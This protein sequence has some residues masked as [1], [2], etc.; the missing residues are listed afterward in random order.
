MICISL[1]WA[2]TS[3]SSQ[4]YFQ[5]EVNYNIHV[6]LNDKLHELNAFETVE[7]VNK[8]PDTLRFLFFH[9]W[10]NAYS[11]NTTGLARQ[12]LSQKGKQRLFND[13]ELKGYI[14]SLDFEVE[15]AP[16]H[17][18]LLP[19]SSDICRIVLN[20]PV[21]PGDTII[22]TTPFHVKIPMGVTSRLGYIGESY[23]IS[24]WY[25]KPAVYDRTGWHPMQYLDQGEFYSE[26]G[27]FD[28]SITLPANYIVGA[29]GNLQN[30]QEAEWL[31]RLASDTSWKF[32]TDYSYSG[33]PP[34]SK[35]LKTLRY[36]ENMIH[37]FAWFADKRFHVMKGKVKLPESGREV[38][39]F[40]LFTNEQAELWKNALKYVNKAILYLSNLIGDYPYDTFTAVQ[41]ALTAGEGMEYPGITVIGLADDAYSLDKVI[42]HEV[43]HSWFYSAL[44]SDERRYPFMDEGI[45]SAYEQRY[46]YEKYP[47]KKLWELYFKKEK[48]AKFFH[49][50]KMP[51]KRGDELEWLFQ[52]RSNLE[53]PV[54][55]A[56]TDYN[57][58]NYSLML[59]YKAGMGF[60]YVRNW[61]GD[62]L[63]DSTMH[64]YYLK[65]KFKHPYPDDIRRIFE[66]HTD[67]D[68]TWFF[69]DFLGTTRR[70]DYKVS[71]LRNQQLLVKNVGEMASPLVICGMNGDSIDFVKWI[72]GFE[73]KKWV[74]IPPGN[75]S[76]IKIDPL[77]IT[78][79]LY[80]LNNNI[81]MYG[82]FP[83]ADPVLTQ[84]F[85]TI[86]D[87]DKRSIMFIPLVNWNKEDGFMA[88]LAL[89]NGLFLPKHFEYFVV[90]FYSV[91]NS[92]MTGYGRIS[93]NIMPWNNLIRMAKISLEGT[94]FGALGTQNYL[95]AKFGSELYLRNTRLNNPL[96][97]MIYGY[98]NYASDLLQIELL[99]KAKMRTYL[100]FGYLMQK[101]DL[102][103]PFTLSTSFES[104]KAFKKASVEFTYK[105]NYYG[106]NNG[107][108]I[109]L[110]SGLVI[111]NN[112]LVP[113]Y[114]LA[115][116]GRS[117]R[118]QYLYQGTYPDRFSKSVE[119]FWTRQ[120]TLSEG[121]LVSPVNDSL[122][123]S[124][125]LISLTFTSTLPGQTARIPVKPFI[126]ILLNDHGSGRG[127]NSPLFYEAGL[128][129]GIWNVFEIY[130]PLL[131]SPNI[132]SI[133]GSFKDRIRIVLNLDS[134]NQIRL[135]KGLA[136]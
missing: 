50:D 119:T 24:Q 70:V 2:V 97:K 18:Y 65:W 59:Y 96:T 19:D 53:Q 134:F 105:F 131:V 67:K 133:T 76:E 16:V 113:F 55:L 12:L 79:E 74:D 93:V 14:D 25:P 1:F 64:D 126:N 111:K 103:N 122:G 8:S 85:F 102:V 116:G 34:S 112:A 81:R 110:F 38:T 88:G 21:N 51:A 66:S 114:A 13:P 11:G 61:L 56:A 31:G 124:R 129:A 22:I 94:Q 36:T 54:N 20:K 109:R 123:Y 121:G 98:Y 90:P 60:N 120:M 69:N 115:A 135:N 107:L 73:R 136:L 68:V 43:C 41:S 9:L 58:L 39:T 26:F 100:Q 118:E 99:E 35:D 87:P 91:K 44:G 128:K 125:W 30:E 29:T 6:S 23:Q 84:F 62:S 92:G 117:G 127:N 52:A 130:V 45:T 33:F 75:Y 57:P 63:F 28:V 80:R 40:T 95:L 42:V 86:E 89:H 132:G 101:T 77:H 72:D 5:Q 108:D 82:I 78:P 106:L 47:G 46:M 4:E 27:N 104:G 71:H 37:D 32:G 83:K 10:P 15:G 48:L 17:W 49:I 7:Y 3:A